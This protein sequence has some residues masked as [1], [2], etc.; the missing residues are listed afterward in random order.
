MDDGLDRGGTKDLRR[1]APALK[2]LLPYKKQILFASFALVVTACATL[3]IGQ[4]VR[5][6]IDNGF[7]GGDGQAL[8]EALSYFVSFVVLLTVGTF[9]RFY[10]VSWI[11]ERISADIRVAVF[12]RLLGMHPGF[13]EVNLPSEIQTRI[14]T[15]TT[16]LQTVIGSSVSV[17]L[18]NVLL[19]FG[20]MILL[21]VTSPFL[22]LIAIG[23][24][25]IVVIPIVFFGRKVR[26]LSRQSQDRLAEVG[27][28]AGESLRHI[29]TVQ[30]FSHEDKDEISFIGH[31]E[32]AFLVAVRRIKHRALLI[33][34]VMLLVFGAVGIMIW[35]GGQNVILGTTSPGELA[36]FIFYAV[37][38]AGAVGAISE[39]YSDLQRAA[40][41]TERLVEL[42]ESP[43]MI[44]SPEQ[45]RAL[46]EENIEL[47]FSKVSF[48]Y[49]TRPEIQVLSEI[50]FR[51]GPGEMVAIVGPSG[52]G[53][54]TIFDLTQ[55]F[56]DPTS[57]SIEINGAEIKEFSLQE[58]R[59]KMGYVA[60]DPILFSGSLKSN[61]LYVNRQVSE[62]DIKE[63]LELAKVDFIDDLPNGLETLIG[64]DGVG[65]SGGQRQ[66]IAIARALLSK[67]SILLLDE[68]TSA[69]DAESESKIRS[70]IE[71]LKGK[72]SILVVA[73]RIS[74][75]R[76]ADRILVIDKGR[77][78]G[79]GSHEQL[80][81]NN[82]LY[83]KFADIQFVA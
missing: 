55:R 17:A 74:T 66:R 34:V 64:E 21:I 38:V 82:I 44:S 78:I 45:P 42:L 49:E 4:G 18:R 24:V 70:S 13:F 72:M 31:A 58:I 43:V 46:V 53:K 33:A 61:L 51:V 23:V 54:S 60:Q 41:A 71:K 36:A 80:R 35:V 76:Q 10:F 62:E 69:L 7:A 11:G 29:K 26:H 3:L 37:L 19:F 67:P 14:T 40:G 27:T 81:S 25:P 39:V 22:A 50:D 6:L 1:L 52:A 8:N 2:F 20:G 59:D 63:A 79:E 9:V 68:A 12:S 5:L 75:V 16:L 30:A 28:F 47:E 48:A 32:D 73:H 57:G 15:D 83:E 56:Y 77:L 65:L